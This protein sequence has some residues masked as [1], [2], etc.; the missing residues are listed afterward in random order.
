VAGEGGGDRRELGGFDIVVV[1]RLGVGVDEDRKAR[2]G[3]AD[4]GEQHGKRQGVEVVRRAD[5]CGL[6]VPSSLLATGR[7]SDNAD[8]PGLVPSPAS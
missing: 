5:H 6:G 4:I 3:A 8:G 1:A 7:G 2:I